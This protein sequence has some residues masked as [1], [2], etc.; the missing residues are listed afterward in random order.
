MLSNAIVRSLEQ[1]QPIRTAFAYES[2][3][4]LAEVVEIADP[5]AFVD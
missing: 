3:E 5:D 2:L 4:V 1:G